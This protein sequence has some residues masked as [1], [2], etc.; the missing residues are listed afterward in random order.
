M[1]SC[2]CRHAAATIH[3]LLLLWPA[4]CAFAQETP[5]AGARSEGIETITVTARRREELL[6]DVPAS[7]SAF[8]EADLEKRAVIS[9]RELGQAVP[10]LN[11][12]NVSG[13]GN[14]AKIYIRGVGQEDF[15][16]TRDMG[17]GVYLDGVYLARLSSPTFDLF[18]VERFEVL[19]GPQGTLFGRNTVGGAINI[20]SVKPKM[21]FESKLDLEVGNF[22]AWGVKGMINVPLGSSDKAAIRASVYSRDADGWQTNIEDGSKFASTDALGSRV[23]LRYAP[24]DSWEFN[25][26]G[27]QLR[28]RQ[29]PPVAH[30]VYG[31]PVEPAAQPLIDAL[32]DLGFDLEQE[33]RIS[34]ESEPDEVSIDTLG[35]DDIDVHGLAATA[36][37][38]PQA[39][40]P[41]GEI[42]VKTIFSWR[43]QEWTLLFDEEMSAAPLLRE[44][45][46][47]NPNDEKQ[48][49]AELQLTG[50][51]VDDRLNY[52]IGLYWFSED[53]FFEDNFRFFPGTDFDS[54]PLPVRTEAEAKSF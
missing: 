37:W 43:R 16:P 17:V 7:V 52:V 42:S 23:A 10:N 34:F 36:E 49:T 9:P 45:L 15:T 14:S 19:R 18:D 2:S 28:K 22:S 51:A 38:T 39:S 4:S 12:E 31:Q 50:K 46:V 13:L 6:Q 1:S 41:L 30:C 8:S 53:A 5:P 47:D 27:D 25:L 3:G 35:N 26:V 24:S 29:A 44:E 32:A 48:Y 33:C 11:Y 54:G 20:T 21:E 40:G